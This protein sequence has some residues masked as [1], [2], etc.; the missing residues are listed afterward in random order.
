MGLAR[1]VVAKVQQ[2]VEQSTASARLRAISRKGERI[3]HLPAQI[4]YAHTRI[5][6]R[7]GERILLGG[8]GVG[9]QVASG[10]QIGTQAVLV[11]SLE[12]A[13]RKL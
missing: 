6:E 1:A 2:Q 3:Y 11:F 8:G 13:R 7:A 5:N 9:G 10:D 4:D 12:M